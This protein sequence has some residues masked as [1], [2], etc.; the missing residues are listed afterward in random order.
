MTLQ[1][2]GYSGIYKTGLCQTLKS[3][4]IASS[5]A[6]NCGERG[7]GVRFRWIH[8]VSFWIF[9]LLSVPPASR[10]PYK[11][12]Q[13][14]HSWSKIEKVPRGIRG[15]K[16]SKDMASSRNSVSTIWVELS[17]IGCLTSQLTVFQS[18]MWRHIDVQADWRRSLTYGRAP[19]AI[20]IS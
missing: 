18:Y 1:T 16:S 11:W 5:K 20:D 9:R 7:C 14:R 6:P 19:N 2:L 4:A 15:E 12:N 8:K 3:V 17:W 10:C 13:A